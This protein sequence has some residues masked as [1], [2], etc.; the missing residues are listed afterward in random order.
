MELSMTLEERP[1]VD[2]AAS[3]VDLPF[4]ISVL[5]ADA[6]YSQVRATRAFL[7]LLIALFT[8]AIALGI[9]GALI[10]IIYLIVMA[11][12]AAVG[13]Y[14]YL[15]AS[16]KHK[17]MTGFREVLKRAVEAHLGRLETAAAEDESPDERAGKRRNAFSEAAEFARSLLRMAEASRFN[18]AR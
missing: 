11:G 9:G 15:Q 2:K 1:I 6:A 8:T 14:D 10:W 13:T 4:S 3:A 5:L 12:L 7:G 17:E 16:A 18:S